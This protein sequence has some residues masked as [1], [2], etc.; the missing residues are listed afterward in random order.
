[1]VVMAARN[2]ILVADSAAERIRPVAYQTQ[3]GFRIIRL[4]EIDDSVPTVGF[5][6]RFLVRDPDGFELDITVEIAETVAQGLVKRSPGR[7]IPESSSWLSCAE[8]YLANYL[9]ENG[10]Y[11]PDARLIVDQPILDDLDLALRLDTQR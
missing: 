2:E 6:H 11:P 4:C 9:C 3:N 8:R 1:M 5:V 7:L 10:D